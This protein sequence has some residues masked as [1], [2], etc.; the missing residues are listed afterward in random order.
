M[1]SLIC[2]KMETKPCLSLPS[3]S[4]RRVLW[5]TL[6]DMLVLGTWE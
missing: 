5:L 3:V 4:K 1:L 2:K 6:E